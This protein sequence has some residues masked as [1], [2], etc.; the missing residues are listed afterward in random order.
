MIALADTISVPVSAHVQIYHQYI[1]WAKIP[2]GDLWFINDN[3]VSPPPAIRLHVC[4]HRIVA[5]WYRIVH[6]ALSSETTTE[7]V[8]IEAKTKTSKYSRSTASFVDKYRVQNRREYQQYRSR[9]Y[10]D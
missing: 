4:R 10:I 7:L 6:T 2:N 1:S 5:H 9:P 3:I 8:R